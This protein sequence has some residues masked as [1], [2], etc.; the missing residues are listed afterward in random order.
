MPASNFDGEDLKCRIS[1][2]I[3]DEPWDRRKKK[4]TYA[5]G[6]QYLSEGLTLK[7][8]N[9][10]FMRFTVALEGLVIMMLCTQSVKPKFRHTRRGFL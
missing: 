8:V 7:I 10:I 2:H 6:H 3:N 9:E 1:V 5:I 4:K